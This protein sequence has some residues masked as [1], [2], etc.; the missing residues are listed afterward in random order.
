MKLTFHSLFSGSS[1]NASCVQGGDQCL[2]VDAGLAGKT[3]LAA[4]GE[5]GVRG[6][7]LTGILVTHEHTDH[8]RGVGVLS[9]KFD[10]PVYAS[11]G[12]WQAMEGQIG[13]LPFRNRRLFQPN[14]DFYLGDI[15][16]TPFSI[17]HDAREP[18]G[19]S[20]TLRGRKISVA[21]D[22]G[23]VSKVV[24]DRLDGSEMVLIESNHDLDM[25]R[26]GPYPQSLKRRIL[27]KTGHLS[28]GDCGAA[29]YP[30]VQSGLKCA[31]LGHLSRENNRPEL[32]FQ[33][34]CES[35]AENG[36]VAGRDV[37]IEM[38]YRDRAAIGYAV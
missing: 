9:R 17:P 4:L 37:R 31:Y 22:L 35:L 28:N 20:F 12:T 6:D 38:T 21:T 25:L 1:G 11:T 19:Y 27:G 13:E 8:I 29:L 24:M 7:Y 16:V 10:I 15:A 23:Y 26:T 36:C 5:I 2:L 30:L 33:T 3:V 34:V 14:E 32:A 18:V